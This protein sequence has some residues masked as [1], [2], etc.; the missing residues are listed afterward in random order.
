VLS[1]ADKNVINSPE[2]AVPKWPV[3]AHHLVFH[4][5]VERGNGPPGWREG[6]PSVE[7]KGRMAFSPERLRPSNRQLV[8]APYGRSAAIS[9]QSG[10]RWQ[11]YD[12]TN[13]QVE[14]MLARS[15]FQGKPRAH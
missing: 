11:C 15:Y 14:I 1:V 5:R 12:L 10:A 8:A 13:P 3:P 4:Q 9:H 6:P 7:P 2:R